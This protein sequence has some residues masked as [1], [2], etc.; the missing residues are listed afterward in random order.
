MW[1][2]PVSYTTASEKDFKSTRPKLW[3]R[4]ERS[5]VVNDISVGENDWFI[6]NI[7]QTGKVKQNFKVCL[8]SQNYVFITRTF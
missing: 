4:G 2:I 5:I 8:T 1:W 7:Q 3:L 6:A